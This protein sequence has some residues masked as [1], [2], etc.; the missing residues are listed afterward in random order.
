ME[1]IGRLAGGV[2]HDLTLLASSGLWRDDPADCPKPSA[3][4]EGRSDLKAAERAGPGSPPSAG[5]RCSKRIVDLNALVSNLEAML[6][7]LI[8]EDIELTTTLAPGLGRVKVDP[9]R[10]SRS[11]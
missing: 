9:D 6:V 7:R 5:C 1:A 4:G 3:R 10:S 11:S 8:G 2:A